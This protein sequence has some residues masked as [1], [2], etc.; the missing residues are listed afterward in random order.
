MRTA[1]EFTAKRPKWLSS[2]DGRS[3]QSASG[4]RPP[5][6]PFLSKASMKTGIGHYRRQAYLSSHP[7]YVETREPGLRCLRRS[8]L[9][10]VGVGGEGLV[11][12]HAHLHGFLLVQS[13][14]IVE[15]ELDQ[16]PSKNT[17]LVRVDN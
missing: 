4:S 7:P 12:R 11:K 2:Q 3:D 9:E 8:D 15:S 1:R 16:V 14:R 5:F 13:W 17:H 10:R 6:G